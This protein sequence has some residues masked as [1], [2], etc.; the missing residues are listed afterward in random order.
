ML[1]SLRRL[2]RLS[3]GGLLALALGFGAACSGCAGRRKVSEEQA[4]QGGKA[5]GAKQAQMM[6]KGMGNPQS[7]GAEAK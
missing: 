2:A 3:V 7:K 1:E 5:I 6:Q 4:V